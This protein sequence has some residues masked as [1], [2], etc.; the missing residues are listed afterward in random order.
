NTLH[1]FQDGEIFFYAGKPYTLT[2]HK[3]TC[4]AIIVKGSSFLVSY[5]AWPMETQV[6][7]NLIKELYRKAA[8]KRIVPL[9]SYWAEALHLAIPP[10]SVRDSKSRW[11]SCSAKGRLSFSLR[12]QILDDKQLSYLVLHEMA[13]V[14][15]FNHSREFHALLF[16]HMSD[17]KQVQKSIFSLQ[18]ESQLC[19]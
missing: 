19:H 6:V 13:H 16:Y 3:G 7:C 9:L 5:T 17:Y 2:L 1:S 4:D 14:I 11:G 8:R 10:F 18:Q 12:C 15:H